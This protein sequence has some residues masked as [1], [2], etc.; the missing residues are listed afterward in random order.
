[1]TTAIQ[2]RVAKPEER[3]L[4]FAIR[5]DVFILEQNVPADEEFD[6][7]EDESTHLLAWAQAQVHDQAQDQ[8]QAQVAGTARLRFVDGWAKFERIAVAARWRGHKVGAALMQALINQS[9]GHD[10][11]LNAQCQAQAF[12]ERWD[13][14]AVGE[15]FLDAGIPHVRMERHLV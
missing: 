15:T 6:Q 5:R 11:C 13:F 1:M 3:E 12:Y 4:A 2:V 8:E 10:C 7:Y 14:V 9:D